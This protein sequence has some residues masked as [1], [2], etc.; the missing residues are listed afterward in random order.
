M[1]AH[2]GDRIVVESERAAQPGRAGV[3]EEILCE[4]PV[5]VR[6][7]WDDGHTS[8][9]TPSAAPR[10]SH[11]RRRQPRHDR[12]EGPAH[13]QGPRRPTRRASV[14]RVTVPPAPQALSGGAKRAD[15]DQRPQ[16]SGRA[17]CAASLVRFA[18]RRVACR[19]CGDRRDPD[20]PAPRRDM[21]GSKTWEHRLML[22]ACEAGPAGLILPAL[23][24]R[25]C[26]TACT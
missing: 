21:R 22:L 6:V 3:I 18:W 7:R 12:S 25:S 2:A 1:K 10:P 17:E 11:P 19:P 14:M 23:A 5:R 16:A 24:V 13:W 15:T 20:R 9:L 4:D 8:V 26:F